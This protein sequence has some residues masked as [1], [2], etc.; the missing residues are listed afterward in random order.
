MHQR[1]HVAATEADER[2]RARLRRVRQN[3]R[4]AVQ[5]TVARQIQPVAVSGPSGE[6]RDVTG[7]V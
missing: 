2:I 7:S 3:V 1:E 6:I 4:E 5:Q